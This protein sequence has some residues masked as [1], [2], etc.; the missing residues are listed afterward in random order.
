MLRHNL[1]SH[2]DCEGAID[3]W[4]GIR[5]C[6]QHDF[7]G[8]IGGLR[9][10][11]DR[12]API[13]PDAV[14]LRLRPATAEQGQRRL[15]RADRQTQGPTPAGFL[16][17]G[18]EQAVNGANDLKTLPDK[19]GEIVAKRLERFDT[20]STGI[21][22]E[23][24]AFAGGRQPIK[25]DIEQFAV[26]LRRGC[27][28][29]RL[30]HASPPLQPS[31]PPKGVVRRAFPLKMGFCGV[32]TFEI[33]RARHAMPRSLSHERR[34]PDLIFQRAVVRGE[35]NMPHPLQNRDRHQPK[36][37]RIVAAFDLLQHP[38]QGK[39]GE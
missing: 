5:G 32:P 39:A 19:A 17:V 3:G 31:E 20:T 14:F 4:S 36:K 2:A 10:S 13:A 15:S 18:P 9:Q 23:P 11:Q 28:D 35:S 24:P 22:E 38:F 7:P 6:P 27:R 29:R 8:A 25:H 33:E 16:G 12:R 21:V 1:V 26:L 37:R 34:Q 30:E